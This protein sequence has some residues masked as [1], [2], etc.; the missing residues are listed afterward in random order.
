M[1]MFSKDQLDNWFSFDYPSK[2]ARKQYQA[3]EHLHIYA[4]EI[5]TRAVTDDAYL[6]D[7]I[8]SVSIVV[9]EFA[10]EIDLRC[11]DGFHKADAMRYL[12]LFHD[13]AIE[14]VI[15]RDD[16]EYLDNM[17]PLLT[18]EL[19]KVLFLAKSAIRCGGL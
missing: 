1:T 17:H 3:L 7:R 18:Q 2:E 16:K 10:E 8:D 14:V 9:R 12:R 5:V 19:Q 4:L 15:Q 11:P 13:I 6:Q